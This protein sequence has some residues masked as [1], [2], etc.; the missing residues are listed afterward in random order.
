MNTNNT[1]FEV[2]E[3]AESRQAALLRVAE[4]QAAGLPKGDELT[5]DYGTDPLLNSLAYAMARLGDPRALVR[6]DGGLTDV[7]EANSIAFREVRTPGDLTTSTRALLLVLAASDGRPLVVHRQAGKA[8]FFD[9]QHSTAVQSLPA[10]LVLKPFAFELY[11]AWPQ[12]LQSVFQLFSFSFHSNLMP[13]LAVLF[14]SLVVALFNLSIPALTSYLVG[15]VLPIGQLRL[16]A[17]TSLVVLL[18]AFSTLAAQFFS[19]LALVRM[20]SL[21]NLRVEAALWSHLL[22]LPLAF[23]SQ[24]GTADLIT[25]VASIRQMRQLVSN[26]LLSTGLALMFSLGNLVLMVTYQAQLTLVAGL[27]SLVSAVV[28][29]LLVWRNARL[30]G[31]LQQGQAQVSDLGLQAVTGMAQ[32]RVG[33]N[34]PFVFERWYR[35]VA[36]LASLQRRGEGY[37]NALEILGRVLNPLGQALIFA[38]FVLLI[39]Q[40]QT[41]AVSSATAVPGG[42]ASMGANQLVASF[43]SFQAAYISFNGQLSA[44]A[45][46][47]ASTVA[48]LVVLWQRSAVVMF[49][50]PEENQSEAIRQHRLEGSFSIQNLELTYPG[51]DEPI[52][53]DIDLEIPNGTYTAITGP[54]G[55]GK[56]TLLRS[57]LRLMDYQAGVISA[58][59]VDIRELAVRPYRRQFGVVLQNTPLPSGSIYEI[60]RAGRA[61][62]REEVWDVLAQAGIADDVRAMGMQLETVISEGAGAISGGQRQRFALARALLGQPRVLVLDEATSALDAPTQALITRTL[63]SLPITRIAIAHRL[64]TIESANQIA[65]LQN[66]VV[67]ELG[68]YRELS[69]TPGGYLNCAEPI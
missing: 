11:A 67:S 48:K 7:L 51:A 65:V 15:T 31:P 14:S 69:R 45:A 50:K 40:A 68:T 28:M 49:A 62:S 35:D 55:C 37:A 10:D 34:E 30:E 26:G 5:T 9:P 58:D 44:M 20:E 61:Y 21:L 27:F 53:R 42:L 43:V 12:R 47:V 3:L 8:V 59:G 24:L 60:V 39:N 1:D 18:V 38:V 32:V 36:R 23:F 19:S 4:A 6:A 66:G 56:T 2:R 13:L 25:R 64:S 54:S 63:E 52:L 16:I 22:R 57:L 33:G 17:E 46:Q 41:D 29:A